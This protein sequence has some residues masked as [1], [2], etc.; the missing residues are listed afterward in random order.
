MGLIKK[1]D[2]TLDK[3]TEALYRAV[4]AYVEAKGGYLMGIDGVRVEEERHRRDHAF[5][6]A[7]TCVGTVPDY[8]RGEETG[9]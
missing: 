7:V 4:S 9:D 2:H 5:R 8:A 1:G 6:V 3:A